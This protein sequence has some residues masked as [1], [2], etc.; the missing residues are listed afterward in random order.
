[1]IIYLLSKLLKA[2]LFSCYLAALAAVSH[3]N[4]V[5]SYSLG[6][7]GEL[8]AFVISLHNLKLYLPPMSQKGLLIVTK[9][10]R[11]SVLPFSASNSALW[12][13]T[14]FLIPESLGNRLHFLQLSVA[15]FLDF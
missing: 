4:C 10:K 6:V 3:S 11:L 12:N 13:S 1:M 9:K 2:S 7:N 8:P 5:S 14:K 15:L